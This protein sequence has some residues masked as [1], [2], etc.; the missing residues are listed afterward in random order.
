MALVPAR[1]AEVSVKGHSI[2]NP[3]ANTIYEE[4]NYSKNQTQCN[5]KEQF[6]NLGSKKE[7]VLK[8]HSIVS[9]QDLKTK[10]I[11]IDWLLDRHAAATTTKGTDY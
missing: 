2:V 8:W 1:I 4:S 6:R 11:E 5:F 10:K 7:V 9:S 3:Q